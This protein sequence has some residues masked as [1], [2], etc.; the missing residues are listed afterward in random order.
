M[1]DEKLTSATLL[2][3]LL[4]RKASS[5][6]CFS[7]QRGSVDVYLKASRMRSQRT[8]LSVDLV[9]NVVCKRFEQVIN[10]VL[11]IPKYLPLHILTD[12]HGQEVS[13]FSSLLLPVWSVLSLCCSTSDSPPV[14]CCRL[15]ASLRAQRP[16]CST[17]KTY[18]A[19]LLTPNM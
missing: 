11:R 19:L 10:I 15:A 16:S 3:S 6:V 5:C 12:T 9:M 17:G 4:S 13:I 18:H 2:R 7:S 1:C 8:C 14:C